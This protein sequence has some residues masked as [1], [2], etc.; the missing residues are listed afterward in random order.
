MGHSLFKWE[1]ENLAL[2]NPQKSKLTECPGA[3]SL[4]HSAR[5]HTNEETEA[6]ER[7]ALFKATQR[8]SASLQ[9]WGNGPLGKQ[10][11]GV[12]LEVDVGQLVTVFWSSQCFCGWSPAEG[13]PCGLGWASAVVSW[14]RAAW[15]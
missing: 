15:E 13:Q 1:E 3:K 6:G 14:K 10:W 4:A 8:T 11:G 9:L 12:V 2:E 7:R 5:S